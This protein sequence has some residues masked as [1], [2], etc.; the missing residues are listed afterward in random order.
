VSC[1]ADET[2][3]P[4]ARRHKIPQTL[5]PVF[6]AGQLNP[7]LW[8]IRLHNELA[9]G[10][11][12]DRALLGWPNLVVLTGLTTALDRMRQ[13]A[14]YARTCNPRVVDSVQLAVDVRSVELAG[15]RARVAHVDGC[16][17]R[18]LADRVAVGRRRVVLVPQVG[19]PG[20]AAEDWFAPAD[21]ALR[22][23]VRVEVAEQVVE[24]AVLQYQDDDVVERRAAAR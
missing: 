17:E 6:L 15:I 5:G 4:V 7:A 1:H 20:N 2:R 11:L 12:E 16:R 13:I 8:D 22:R 21:E 23:T 18:R 3:R 19:A 14:A 9:E 24:R 10:P